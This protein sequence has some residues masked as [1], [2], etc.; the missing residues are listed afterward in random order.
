[1]SVEQTVLAMWKAVSERDWDTAHTFYAEDCVFIDVP[2]GSANAAR[3]PD[4][5]VRKLRI[6]L[7]PLAAYVNHPGLILTNG[8]VAIFEHSETWTWLPGQSTVMHFVSV[9]K[10]LDGKITFWKD[11]W[12]MGG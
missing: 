6:S 4:D 5:I 2:V 11:Y 8:S 3:G 7:D 9:H 10:V 1:M 12:D